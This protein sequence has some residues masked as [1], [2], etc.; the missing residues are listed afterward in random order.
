MRHSILFLLCATSI[1]FASSANAAIYKGRIIYT[2]Q[3]KSCHL[4]GDDLTTSRTKVQWRNVMQENG[5]GLAKLHFS[6]KNTKQAW[7]YFSSDAYAKECRH[8]E[9]FMLEYAK[10]SGNILACE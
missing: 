1:I 10:D 4:K 9:D 3:C 5:I 8:L 2:K 6:A 7:E